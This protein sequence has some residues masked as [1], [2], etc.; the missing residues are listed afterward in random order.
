MP[1]SMR[2][3]PEMPRNVA[4]GNKLH[5]IAI[6][7]LFCVLCA[8]MS[9]PVAADEYWPQGPDISTPS[10]IVI[11]QQTGTVL[12][13]KDATTAHYPASITKIMTTMLALEYCDL[14][15]VVTFSKDAVYKNEGDTSHI[16]RDVGEEMTMEECLYAIM[17]MSANECAYAVA[18]HVGQKLGGDY[19]TFIDLMNERAQ[20]L[21][22]VNTHFNNC[23]GLPDD[24]HWTCAY[25]MALIAQAAYQNATFRTITGTGKYTIGPT[26]KHSEDTYLLNHHNMLYPYS[27]Y[28]YLYDAC[29]GGKTGYTTVANYTLVTYAEKNGLTLVCV[30]MDTGTP[31]QYKDTISLMDYCFANFTAV[32]LAENE[33][34]FTG[35]A[36]ASVGL[37][38]SNP[39]YAQFDTSTYIILPTGA[40]LSEVSYEASSAA[41]S[42]KGIASLNFYYGDHLVGSV[43]LVQSGASVVGSIFA[44]RTAGEEGTRTIILRPIHILLAIC[45]VLFLVLV[46]L[47]CKKLSD[48]YYVRQH[49]REE[50]RL[51]KERFREQK[52]S[53]YH[54]KDRLFR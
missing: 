40:D 32:N 8:S 41:T 1:S 6:M 2:T 34:A 43:E 18:E 51:E 38:N 23:N 36:T 14:D 50:R 53:R 21:G 31:A 39:S 16:A 29:T 4:A 37:M 22:C 45:I 47:I 12:Y 30:V 10:A 28:D 24:D 49:N 42:R 15:E 20:E 26:N 9:E 44:S 48:N 7:V 17:L 3:Q 46:I 25:D 27:S 5:I 33:D 54:K 11:E 19:Q 52:R 35:S 13:E